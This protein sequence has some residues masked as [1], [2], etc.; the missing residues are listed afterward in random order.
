[1]R[2][3]FILLAAVFPYFLTTESAPAQLSV[4]AQ[5]Q[6]ACEQRYPDT[7]SS[8]YQQCLNAHCSE[9]F[10]SVDPEPIQT[11]PTM[12]PPAASIAASG[13]WSTVGFEERSAVVPA[14]Q[15]QTSLG[16][17]CDGRGGHFIALAGVSQ[18]DRVIGMLFDNGSS[19]FPTFSN[20]LTGFEIKLWKNHPLILAIKTGNAVRVFERDGRVIGDYS[21]RNSSRAI[22]VAEANCGN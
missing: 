18:S 16:Y 13:A 21:L 7:A 2:I 12:Q 9:V 10:E 3:Q 15:S 8:A 22:G 5:C 11:N 6:R 20:Q 14:V 19:H 4:A 17:S 1:M